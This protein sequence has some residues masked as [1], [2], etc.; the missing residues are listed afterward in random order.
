MGYVEYTTLRLALSITELTR[1]RAES[2]TELALRL[3]HVRIRIG[4]VDSQR[5]KRVS[6]TVFC[7]DTCALHRRAKLLAQR[8][9]Q[10][11]HRITG[12]FLSRASAW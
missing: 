1:L 4:L 6:S 12:P 5:L 8:R 9:R 10:A 7:D 3:F 11:T 2:S